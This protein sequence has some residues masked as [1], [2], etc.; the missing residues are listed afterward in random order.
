MKYHKLILLGTVLLAS[1]IDTQA[2]VY[3]TLKQDMYFNVNNGEKIVK[4]SG[5]GVSII[6]VDEN[7]YLIRLDAN[8]NDLVS[9][10]LVEIQGIIT[11][12]KTSDVTIMKEP[13][14]ESEVLETIA[15]DELVMALEKDGDFYKVKVNDQVGYIHA[16]DLVNGKLL[17]LDQA[18]TPKSLGEEIIS[19]AKN[20]LG[21][22]YVYGGN[23]LNTG[24]DCSGFAQQ[25]MKHF[26]ISLE[27][28]SRAQYASNGY[29]I[30]ET[31]LMPGDLV[32]YGNDGYVNHV[33]IYA[34]DGK[35]IHA[36]TEK[37]GIIMSNLYY[38]KAIIGI[39]RVI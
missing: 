1:V 38:G 21:G 31:E 18:S 17:S 16:S 4:E 12:T 36:S 26:N 32:F 3:G 30:S 39:K 8:S 34:G 15:K 7:N 22:R 23:N 33:A 6:D 29:K 25:V 2:A 27:R 35:I 5:T 9:K 13:S 24:V 11:T 28:S 10:K 14:I 19:Y 20:Y 37:T